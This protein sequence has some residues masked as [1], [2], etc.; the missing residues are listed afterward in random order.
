MKCHQI[1]GGLEVI[2]QKCCVE[3]VLS[4]PERKGC[5]FCLAR[6][7]GQKAAQA[8]RAIVLKQITLLKVHPY[9]STGSL[10]LFRRFHTCAL[11]KLAEDCH[12]TQHLGNNSCRMYIFIHLKSSAGNQYRAENRAV[13]SVSCDVNWK[14]K[15]PTPAQQTNSQQTGSHPSIA[16]ENI[17]KTART[18]M[19]ICTY[20]HITS[21]ATAVR[22]IL[23]SSTFG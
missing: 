6:I 8:T 15:K 19:R 3:C 11:F 18:D 5:V 22:I 4:Q 21:C 17:M 9:S 14:E 12:A 13:N 1:S 23:M 2:G 16:G 20:K 7:D 10:V